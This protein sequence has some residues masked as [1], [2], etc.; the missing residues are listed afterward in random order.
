[1]RSVRTQL[2]VV[3]VTRFGRYLKIDSPL[4][5][6]RK[7]W[8]LLRELM[9]ESLRGQY[10]IAGRGLRDSNF[11]KTA[12]LMVEH[13][14]QGAMGL[15]VNRPSSVTVA[16]ALSEHFKLPETEDLVFVGG[17]VEPS[18]LF[19]VHNTEDLDENEPPV[20]PGVYVGSSPD[21]FER[22]VSSSTQGNP[23]L[24]FRIF[25]GCAGWGPNQLEGELERGDWYLHPAARE[26]VFH[27]NPY[28]VWE[29]LLKSL[30]SAN[31]FLPESRPERPEWN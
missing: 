14:P 10:L 29:L 2:A 11:F 19:I 22:V 23:D 12:V 31:A 24:H 28:E 17:P 20:V 26:T 30:S 13:G 25:C 1:M 21:V 7:T 8:L 3:P 4:V 18:S 27:E 5:D 16:H 6:I 15:V 9:S